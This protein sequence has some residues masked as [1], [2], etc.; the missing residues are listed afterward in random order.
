MLHRHLAGHIAGSPYGGRSRARS[1]WTRD[2]QSRSRSYVWRFLLVQEGPSRLLGGS[3]TAIHTAPLRGL[4]LPLPSRSRPLPRPPT[5]HVPASPE[6]CDLLPLASPI[7][8]PVPSK[9]LARPAR[10]WH[11]AV[12]LLALA[13]QRLRHAESASRRIH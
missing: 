12:S 6:Q 13:R 2:G 9:S 8:R 1:G 7:F 5:R 4:G 3:K 10:E 11:Y